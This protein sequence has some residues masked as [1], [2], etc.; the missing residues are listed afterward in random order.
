M[1]TTERLAYH[2][3]SGRPIYDVPRRKPIVDFELRQGWSL[4]EPQKVEQQVLPPIDGASISSTA[5]AD[6]NSI[7]CYQIPETLTKDGKPFEPVYCSIKQTNSKKVQLSSKGIRCHCS[8]DR[9]VRDVDTSPHIKTEALVPVE[10]P[11]RGPHEVTRV[12]PSTEGLIAKIVYHHNP[13]VGVNYWAAR[14][15]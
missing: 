2:A 13:M 10:V 14:L 8:R 5:H 4:E 12:R 1:A 9:T 11:S 7:M 15:G 6:P 3:I